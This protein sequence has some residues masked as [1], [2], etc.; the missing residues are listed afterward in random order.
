MDW[1]K[2]DYNNEFGSKWV[3]NY[4]HKYYSQITHRHTNSP[5]LPPGHQVCVFH[6]VAINILHVVAAIR[7]YQAKGDKERLLKY[8]D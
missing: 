5:V 7:R 6:Q 4:K 3:V 1:I 2:L 8:L